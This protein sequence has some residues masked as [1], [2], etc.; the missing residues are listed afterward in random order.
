MD[1]TLAALP[2]T[3]FLLKNELDPHLRK[4]EAAVFPAI[5][6]AERAARSSSPFASFAN[7]IRGLQA[8]HDSLEVALARLR[9]ITHNHHLPPD[10][11]RAYG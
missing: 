3:L 9:A 2:E 5:E 8:E 7:P 1:G 11:A 10:V 4:E 6:A